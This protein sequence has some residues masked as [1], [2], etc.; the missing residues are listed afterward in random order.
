[1]PQSRK[2]AVEAPPPAPAEST[3]PPRG[4]LIV[5]DEEQSRNRLQT[6]LQADADLR[7]DVTKDGDQVLQRLL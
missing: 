4:V 6:L 7:V 2:E 1:M 5:E 3:L